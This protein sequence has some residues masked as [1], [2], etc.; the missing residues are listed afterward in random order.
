MS[1]IDSGVLRLRIEPRDDLAIDNTA[2]AVVNPPRRGRV[3]FVSPGD[4][5]LR[6]ALSTAKAN[7][8]S[9]I[10]RHAPS[11]LLTDEY[12][13]SAEGGAW[14]LII[15]DRC[16][17]KKMPR[18]NTAW[19]GQLP[20]DDR[21]KSGERIVNP[22]IVDTERTHPLVQLV[23]VGDFIIAEVT[24]LKPPPGGVSLF[25]A[26]EGSIFAI[27]PREWFR[28]AVLGFEFSSTDKA[29]Q[30]AINTNWPL[31]QSFPVFIH[32]MLAFLGGGSVLSEAETLRPGRPLE[33]KSLVAG[34]AAQVVTPS[35]RTVSLPPNQQQ[36]LL[37]TGTDE[38]GVYEVRQGKAAAR[39]YAVNLF[40]PAESEI[41]TQPD[42]VVKLGDTDVKTSETWQTV[43]RSIVKVLLVLA[44]AVLMAEW[45]I[46]NRRVYV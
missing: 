23:E 30:T 25:D 13:R 36:T 39:N 27:A 28:D 11:Y 31:R 7:E 16:A 40:S 44:L 9:D 43:R 19:I 34:T 33:V 22:K 14:D 29:G 45:Y 5:A 42:R 41:R 24:L 3:L 46:Y 32:E 1:N 38:V 12:Q 8:L 2:F 35:G 21:W 15:F 20:A 10:T 37:F 4:E 17:P 6:R 26:A 18:A